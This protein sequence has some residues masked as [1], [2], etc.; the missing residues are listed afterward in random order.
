MEEVIVVIDKKRGGRLIL[1]R[2]GHRHAVSG[3]YPAGFD[4]FA[5]PL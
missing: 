4:V 5:T 2:V 1:C 3:R